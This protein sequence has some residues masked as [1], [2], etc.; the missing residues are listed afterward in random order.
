MT[1]VL[2][3]QLKSDVACTYKSSGFAAGSRHV[4]SFVLQ[5]FKNND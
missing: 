3:E 2:Q 1:K 4:H 5:V